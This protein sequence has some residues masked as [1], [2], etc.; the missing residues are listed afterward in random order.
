VKPARAGARWLRE[1][2][3]DPPTLEAVATTARSRKA[4]LYR[5]WPTKAE[6][7]LAAFVE[8]IMHEA[9]VER[10]L[11]RAVARGEIDDAAITDDLWDVLP[12]YLI[13]RCV[14]TGRPP[15]RVR[16]GTS[17]TTCPSPASP[18]TTL[19]VA[20]VASGPVPY[21]QFD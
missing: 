9:L 17:S 21:C 12:G 15:A 11:A 10:V 8:A 2:G 5:R 16:Y 3:Y 14:L 20:V 4:T 19:D 6:L 7:V 18:V 1:H 13:Y